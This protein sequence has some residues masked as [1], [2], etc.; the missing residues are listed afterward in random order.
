[1]NT[2]LPVDELVTVI[3]R[4]IKYAN[5]SDTDA[6]RDLR[7]T[8]VYLHLNTVVTVSS[9]GGVDF[10]VPFIGMQMK[11][12]G[13][14]THKDTHSI[15]LTLIPEDL[16][17]HEIRD[18]QVEA[19]LVDAIETLRRLVTQAGAGEDP[20]VLKDS[21]VELGFAVEEDGTIALGFEGELKNEVTHT[22]R[23][24]LGVPS[25]DA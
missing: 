25:A 12:G 11:I 16:A 20:F 17:E 24:G 14:V 21:I 23:L 13:K 19:V 8:S 5:I 2:G 15:E 10:R 9:G 1:M 22:L 3:K 7:V 6:D 4:A 18:S